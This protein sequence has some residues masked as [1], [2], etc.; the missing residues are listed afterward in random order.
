LKTKCIKKITHKI[1]FDLSP[2]SYTGECGIS[3]NHINILMNWSFIL[4][5][6]A[7]RWKKMILNYPI[8]IH[9]CN[10]YNN[11]VSRTRVFNNNKNIERSQY[12]PYHLRICKY[13]IRVI[14]I[15]HFNGYYMLHASYNAWKYIN[16]RLKPRYAHTL[17]FH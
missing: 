6:Y 4:Y 3:Q 13:T 8:Y 5:Y 9:F 10:C 11:I 2:N 1:F 14:W 7:L 16:K 12:K 17:S 15:I